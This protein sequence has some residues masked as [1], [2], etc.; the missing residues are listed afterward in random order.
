MTA[1]R[2]R[3]QADP[4]S[5]PDRLPPRRGG[6]PSSKT[7]SPAARPAGFVRLRGAR[8]G[9]LRSA[10]ALAAAALLALTGGLALPATAQAEVLVSNIEEFPDGSNGLRGITFAQGFTTGASESN[11]PLT[12]IELKFQTVPSSGSTVTAT[13]KRRNSSG[14]P[15][16]DHA[17]LVSP[18]SFV[19]GNNTFTAPAGTTLAANRTYFVVFETTSTTGPFVNVTNTDDEDGVPGWEMADGSMSSVSGGAFWTDRSQSA[20]IRVNGTDTGP[21]YVTAAEVSTDGQRIAL[22]FNEIL[23]HP[24]YTTTIR[25]AFTV[26]V[27]G[28]GTS[29]QSTSGGMAKVNLSVGRAISAGQTVVVSYDQSAAG[30][31]AL[32]D[33]DGNKV[34]DFTTGRDGIPAVV[35][36]S[37]A[38]RSPPE[39]SG[40]TVAS[41]GV[42]IELAF[43]ED[44]DLPAT[45][46]AALKDA[47]SVT[48]AG[49]TVEIAGLAADGSSGLQIALWSRR[50]CCKI[51]LFGDVSA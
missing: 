19:I 39:L 44:L 35:N 2:A 45:I 43:D 51:R 33:S 4:P 15:G 28:T 27:D 30:T 21:P 41:S 38:D 5:P 3:E 47:F 36:N 8:R 6:S 12:S 18:T 40:A 46:P 42:A 49:D 20:Q 31:E 11:F 50:L 26:T 24:T 10:R 9:L 37:A 7:A 1:P 29:V 34:A 14:R 17:T 13:V 22:T 25:S 16:T 48:A 23:D 32:G